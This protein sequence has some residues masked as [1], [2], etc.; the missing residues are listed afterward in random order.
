MIET[1]DWIYEGAEVAQ[2]V[3]VG[4]M[5]TLTHVERLTATQIVL[6]NGSRY[7]KDYLRRT[8]GDKDVWRTWELL[9]RSDTRVRRALASS[10]MST[11]VRDLDGLLR[12]RDRS[13][14]TADLLAKLDEAA[15][16]ITDARAAVEKLTK[17]G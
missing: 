15:D 6:A 9:P 11:L 17:E 14:G 16:R 1:P 3:S 10:T 4:D 12:V 2:Y 8:V 7:R 13:A 5:V